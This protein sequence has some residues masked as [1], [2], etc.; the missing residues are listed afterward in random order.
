[1]SDVMRTATAW[2]SIGFDDGRFRVRGGRTKYEAVT[3]NCA[4]GGRM[5]K[6][7]RLKILPRQEDRLFSGLREVV[8]YVEPDTV[9]EFLS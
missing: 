9:L 2:D 1:M 4:T 7:S 6:L 8:R 3:Y 5:V